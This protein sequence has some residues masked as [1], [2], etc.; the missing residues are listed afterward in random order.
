VNIT[1][2]LSGGSITYGEPTTFCKPLERYDYIVFFFTGYLA[3]VSTIV[4]VPGQSFTEASFIV[5]TALL[6]PLSGIM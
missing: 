4:S 6:I 2:T 3:H 5:V 1:L